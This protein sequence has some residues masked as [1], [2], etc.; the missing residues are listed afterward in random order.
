MAEPII[1]GL[2]AVEVDEKERQSM[3]ALSGD[4]NRSLQALDQENSVGQPGQSVVSSDALCGR[5]PFAGGFER[6]PEAPVFDSQARQ[7]VP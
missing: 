7:V 3:A 5:S 2:E 4:G 6:L 1:D